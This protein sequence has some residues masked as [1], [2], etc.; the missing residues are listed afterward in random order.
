MKSLSVKSLPGTG[1]LKV[2][3]WSWILLGGFW[4]LLLLSA[5]VI[6]L[7]GTDGEST[8][9]PWDEMLGVIEITVFA[10]TVSSGFAL[11]RQ[12]RLSQAAIWI[13]SIIW[14]SFSLYVIWPKK[15]DLTP[16]F[17][18]FS[19]HLVVYGPS[20]VLSLSLPIITLLSA[21]RKKKLKRNGDSEDEKGPDI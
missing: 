21:I 14:F 7:A 19:L 2:I 12:W 18:I 3:G 11:L 17:G 6:R 13:V 9:G 10:G 16:H 1:Q 4:L 15:W 5:L 8:E 20:L